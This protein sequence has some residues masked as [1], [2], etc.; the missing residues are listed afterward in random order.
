[1]DEI[2]QQPQDAEREGGIPLLGIAV[3]AL[4]LVLVAVGL[5]LLVP[6]ILGYDRYIV[7]GDSMSGTYDRGALLFSEPVATAELREGDVITYIPPPAS[8]LDERVTHRI[9]QIRERA[10]RPPLYRTKGDANASADRWLFT[11]PDPVQNRAV[12][13]IPHAGALYASIARI[14]WPLLALGVALLVSALLIGAHRA[15]PRPV[16]RAEGIQRR[17]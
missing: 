15:R 11:L 1:M 4:D 6:M 2:R 8:G 13:A 17:S 10:G 7:D 9:V 5:L 3:V 14:P 12:G 16:G